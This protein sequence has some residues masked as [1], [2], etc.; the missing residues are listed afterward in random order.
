MC[1]FF[2]PL[3]IDRCYTGD[4]LSIDVSL[5]VGGY[6]G[7]NCGTFTVGKVDDESMRLI[8]VT[9][10]ALDEAIS[11]C[12][13]EQP[14]NLI[15]E[16]IQQI[17]DENGFGTVRDFMGH[18]VGKELHGLPYIAHFRNDIPGTMKTGMTFTIEPMITQGT[19][20]FT[21]WEDGWTVVTQDFGRAAQF[22]HAIL[23]TDNGAEI[24]TV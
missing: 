8:Q 9:Q 3:S 6:H 1:C 15:G 17:C 22:E 18:G 12:G 23:I 20:R 14:L 5:F 24:L 11:I 7:D 4:I 21:M 10:Q 19:E 2:G 16:T 13:P